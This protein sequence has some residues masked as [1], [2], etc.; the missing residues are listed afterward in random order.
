[1]KTNA[2]AKPTAPRS[3]A[4]IDPERAEAP[5]LA[6]IAA[7]EQGERD[8]A[9]GHLVSDAELTRYLAAV[10]RQRSARGGAR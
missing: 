5:S 4:P 3:K 1:M 9:A 6:T 7:M 8:D 10:R 2:N